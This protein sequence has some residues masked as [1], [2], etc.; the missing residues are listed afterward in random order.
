MEKV[1]QTLGSLFNAEIEFREY[2]ISFD[3]LHLEKYRKHI[4]NLVAG[5]DTLQQIVVTFN[6][7][8]SGK[9]IATLNEREKQA[10]AIFG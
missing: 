1:E 9:A 10:V 5:I 6:N 7:S 2:T 4:N 3:K 8:S